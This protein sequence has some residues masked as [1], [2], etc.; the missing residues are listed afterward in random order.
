MGSILARTDWRGRITRRPRAL[1]LVVLCIGITVIAVTLVYMAPLST[2]RLTV[3]PNSTATAAPVP[4]GGL[5]ELP[6]LLADSGGSGRWAI[7]GGSL[8]QI[9]LNTLSAMA[10][11]RALERDTNDRVLHVA[12]GEALT[13]ANGGRV[14]SRAKAHFDFA[15]TA[16]ANDLVARF[17]LAYW[18]LQNG[19]PKPAL[20]KWVGLMRT[21]GTDQLWYRRLWA[22]MP[23][24]AE[25]VGVSEVA[26]QALCTAGM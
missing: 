26:L 14:D 11:E 20:V 21:V 7:L 10:L 22:A 5:S 19:K 4:L 13:L 9:G 6:M 25:Q 15:L 2:H 16:D 1:V 17:Y 24:A 23:S 8:L 12:L 18:L 3:R